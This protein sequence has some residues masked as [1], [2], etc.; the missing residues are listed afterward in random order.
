MRRLLTAFI[1]VS[2][3]QVFADVVQPNGTTIPQG[4]SLSGYLN[5]SANN[6]NLNEGINAITEAAVEPQ[7]F[8]PQCEFGGKYIAKGGG[9]NFAIGWYNVNASRMD[10]DPPKY[11]PVDTGANLNVAAANSDI[12][13]LF[14]FAG[15]LPP[16]G[17]RELTAATIRQNTA[18]AGGLIGL[19][20]IPNPN[21]TGNG[22]ATQYHYTEQRFNTQCTLCSMPGPWYSHLTYRSK[23]LANTF[24]LGFE[25]LDFTNAAGNAGVNGNDLDYEDFLFRFTG[26]TCPA[27]GVPCTVTGAQGSC[28]RGVTDCN[29]GGQTICLPAVTPGSLPE[30][31]DGVDNDCNG[32]V[33][34]GATC[35]GFDQVCDR[36]ACV[37][38]CTGEFYF[39][40]QNEEC[41]NSKCT[42][43]TCV[44]V[45]CDSGEICEGGTCKTA[46]AGITCPYGTEC[47]NGRCIDPCAGVSCASGKVCQAGVCVTGCGCGSCSAGLSCNATS[48][49]CE[50]SAC[51]GMTCDGGTHC[52]AG[53][54]VDDCAG[55]VCP[56]GQACTAGSCVDLPPPPDAGHTGGGSGGGSGHTGGGNGH[57]DGGANADGGADGGLTA[58]TGCGCTSGAEF[59]LLALG[60][61]LLRR[62]RAQR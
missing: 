20:L 16:D 21:G 24:Y 6:D 56:T 12:Q 9:A 44:G 26:L 48:N 55:A 17:M 32:E 52:A 60:V 54:C 1:F 42:D 23:L 49:R 62:R 5:G 28:A 11:V 57:S 3:F 14:P 8:A 19:V 47:T 51:V 15:A 34:N 10:N 40:K 43:P 35:P 30:T 59:S 27:A 7:Q 29:N 31:C 36:G 53:A 18:Y 41:I 38:S 25:D 45:Q 4:G 58:K 37:T 39:C 22:N 61:A 2:S 46:C 13:I 33:D 50:E